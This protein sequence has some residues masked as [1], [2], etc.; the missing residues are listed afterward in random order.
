MAPENSLECIEKG[1]QTGADMI[2]IDI[3][4]TKDGEL[5]VCHDQTIDRTTNGS[6]KIAELTLEEIRRFYIIDKNGNKTTQQLPTLDDVLQLVNGRCKML[7][8]IKRTKNLYQG[9]EK[10]LLDAIERHH[11]STW[12]VVQSFNDSVLGTLHQL[13]SS[14]RLEKLIIFKLL[15]LPVIFDG[16][17]SS[18]SYEKYS[19][20]SSFNFHY[21]GITPSLLKDIHA[22][23]KE[24][25]V[26]TLEGPKNWKGY[27]VDGIIT[28]LPNLW[29]KNGEF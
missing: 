5:V 23:G 7:I 17:F 8:E 2:E 10:K 27:P 22:H 6:G 11:A 20:I 9:I 21:L 4:M 3:H 13:D 29:V 1:V 26:W 25:K 14:V 18:F 28:D 19:Y 24:M 12:V 16:T 15:W